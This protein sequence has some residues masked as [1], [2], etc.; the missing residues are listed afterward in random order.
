MAR[1]RPEPRCCS[2]PYADGRQARIAIGRRTGRWSYREDMYHAGTF[3][4]RD[5]SG[6][7]SRIIATMS[8]WDSQTTVSPASACASPRR[9]DTAKAAPTS[10]SFWSFMR[11]MYH[12]RP[13]RSMA[14]V[15][16]DRA[17]CEGT[18]REPAFKNK[19]ICQL[20]GRGIS[21][22]RGYLIGIRQ[23][24]A[25]RGYTSGRC[26]AIPP[27]VSPLEFGASLPAGSRS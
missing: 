9:M 27:S 26:T 3:Y 19:K 20:L 13:R 15:M 17:M 14:A 7:A 10:C 2:G 11:H 6:S 24:Y 21:R 1:Q 8:S 5:V 22:L 23:T 16:R 12:G 18:P 4:A 25:N